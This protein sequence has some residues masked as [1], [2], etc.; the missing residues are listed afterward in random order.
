M[1][2]SAARSSRALTVPAPAWGLLAAAGA[3]LAPL[4]LVAYLLLHPALNL[5]APE[6]PWQ[7]LAIVGGASLLALLLAIL[8]V[9]TSA[10]VKHYR[11]LFLSFG[12]VAY[13]GFSS[14]HALTTPGLILPESDNLYS[15]TGAAAYLALF[16]AAGFFALAQTRAATYM[17]HVIPFLPVGWFIVTLGSLM[18]AFGALAIYRTAAMAEI[19]LATFP[20]ST[21]MAILTIGLLLYASWHYLRAYLASRLSF[22]LSLLI[23]TLLLAE[24]QLV[25]TISTVWSWSWWCY[26]LLAFAGVAIALHSLLSQRLAGASFR[27]LVE[28]SLNI[29]VS[30]KF[31]VD[32]VNALAALSAAIEARDNETAGHNER[33]AN[34]S[35]RIGRAMGLDNGKL[36]VLAHAGLL[37]DIGKLATP[38][39]IL[40]K[41]GRLTPEEAEIMKSHPTRGLDILAKLGNFKQETAAIMAHHERL[42]G[43]GY[44]Y[45]LK[46]KEIPIEAR[47]IAVVDTYDAITSDRPYRPARTREVAFAIL[48]KERGVTLDTTCVNAIF[49]VL[50]PVERQWSLGLQAKKLATN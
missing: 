44:P 19:P 39:A 32:H 11:V 43:S 3:V 15:I 41:P 21:A 38:D 23:V 13:G 20:Y 18:A 27:S 2:I 5:S 14:L 31:E 37:H 28:N 35:V 29:G 26:H 30:V 34:L 10:Q 47:V 36:R 46:G 6:A 50:A 24:A 8:L 48:H 45:G 22:Q 4:A 12:F 33:V 17:S 49:Q 16:F 9:L 42:D 7:H 40:H 25:I 1:L